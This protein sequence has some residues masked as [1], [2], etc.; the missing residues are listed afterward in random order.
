[1]LKKRKNN[2]FAK[3]QKKNPNG[4]IWKIKNTDLVDKNWSQK[5]EN[6][7]KYITTIIRIKK[8]EKYC[9]QKYENS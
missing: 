1:M 6:G 8:F 5:S 7:Q 4:K 9:L 3:N 2:F